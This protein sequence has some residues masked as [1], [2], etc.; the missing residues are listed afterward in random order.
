MGIALRSRGGILMTRRL[1]AVLAVALGLITTVSVA[2][3]QEIKIAYIDSERI[4]NTLRDTQEAQQTFDRDLET[5]VKDAAERKREI[6]Q[7]R[8]DLDTQ[9]RMLTQAKIEEK[10]GEIARKQADYEEFVQSIWGPTGRVAQRNRELTDPIVR[11]VRGI[12]E[13]IAQEENYAIILDAAG[14]HVVFAAKQFDI[15]EKV[16]E[17][18]RK[19]TGQ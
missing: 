6:E 12:V 5:W 14:G 11:R 17:E 19:Q 8:G 7:L 2:R 1:G 10:Q 18:L 3:A 13:K 4:F 15:T 16:L 9:A